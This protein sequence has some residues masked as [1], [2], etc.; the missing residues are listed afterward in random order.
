MK[1]GKGSPPLCP[2]LA[3]PEGREVDPRPLLAGRPGAGERAKRAA[4]ELSSSAPPGNAVGGSASSG[5]EPAGRW[6]QAGS[7]SQQDAG[8]PVPGLC[9]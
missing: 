5:A 2:G 8:T 6:G 7:P 4:Q 3:A 9:R 1:R